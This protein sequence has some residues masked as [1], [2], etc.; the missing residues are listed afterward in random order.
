MTLLIAYLIMWH[1]GI[2]DWVAWIGVFVL[3][4]FHLANN[5]K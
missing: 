1:I 4:L 5:S 3:W 2:D